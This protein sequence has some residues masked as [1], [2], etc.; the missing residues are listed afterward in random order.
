MTTYSGFVILL[1]E[2]FFSKLRGRGDKGDIMSTMLDRAL[3]VLR[4]LSLR[5]HTFTLCVITGTLL[6]CM[7][8]FRE[9]NTDFSHTTT[10]VQKEMETASASNLTIRIEVAS[11]SM[12]SDVEE[13]KIKMQELSLDDIEEEIDNDISLDEYSEF[14]RLIEAEASTEDLEGKTL[15][16]DVVINRVASDIFPNTISEV[17]NDPGQF[18]PVDNKYI[19]YAVP[20][21]E[22]KLAV[23]RALDGE[24]GSKGALYF[25]KSKATEWGDK[26]YLFRYGNH[27]FYK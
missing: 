19:N 17:I 15:V 8:F 16:A 2:I 22:S 7:G 5:T 26:Q 18:D 27:S 11:I 9:P 1:D 13:E 6:L 24:G 23:M 4:S 20:T 10:S 25:Q 14:A 3:M 12:C 21:H